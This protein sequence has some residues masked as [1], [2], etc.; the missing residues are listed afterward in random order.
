MGNAP[1]MSGAVFK[2]AKNFR[3]WRMD[4]SDDGAACRLSRHA[5]TWCSSFALGEDRIVLRRR[6]VPDARMGK[7]TLKGSSFT[8]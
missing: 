2:M 6:V 3:F 4:C 1:G 5:I 7:V 8:L